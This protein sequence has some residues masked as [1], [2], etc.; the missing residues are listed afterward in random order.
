MIGKLQSPLPE[1]ALE[2]YLGQYE[3]TAKYHL[4]AS[5]P[6]SMSIRELLALAGKDSQEAFLNMGLGYTTTWGAPELREAIAS[7]YESLTADDVLVFS[8]AQE[9]MYW[10]MQTLVGAGD[11][12]IVTVPNYQSMESVPIATGAEVSGLALWEGS[13]STLRWT[14][15]LDRLRALLRPN[16]KAIAINVPNNPTGFVPDTDTYRELV[17]LC[18]ERGIVL[19]SDEVYRG[20]ELDET[21]RR[22]QVADASPTG[23]S[24]N[25]MSKAYG[26]PGLRIGWIASRNRPLLEKLERAKHY[27]T[28]CNSGPSEFLATVALRHGAPIRARNVGIMRENLVPFRAMMDRCSG[29]IEWA[30]P[31]G[32]CVSFPRY[33][34]AD[35]VEAFVESLVKERSAVLLPSSIYASQLMEIPNDRFRIGIG[36]A[37]PHDGW[38]QLE[39]HLRSR[40]R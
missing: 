16:T 8:G 36:R 35:G 22:L 14:L 30:E 13:G 25:V 40:P 21:N 9:A 2:V 33:L 20:I 26:L 29:I 17:E 23:L 1:F 27:T 5:D 38:E 15:D 4:T 7:T 31:D 37:N 6:Q 3:F 28:I 24:M 39:A 18:D 11:H 12:V 10:T 34:G 19:F 32:G